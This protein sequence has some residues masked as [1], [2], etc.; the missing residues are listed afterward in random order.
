HDLQLL[1]PEILG[2][3]VA[4]S[5]LQ[6]VVRIFDWTFLFQKYRL[7]RRLLW[8]ETAGANV[9]E[10][11]RGWRL[12]RRPGFCCSGERK[13]VKVVAT[14]S[15]LVGRSVLISLVPS[16]AEADVATVDGLESTIKSAHDR[17]QWKLTPQVG[18]KYKLARKLLERG[19]EQDGMKLGILHEGRRRHLERQPG[20][21]AIERDLQWRKPASIFLKRAWRNSTKA[22]EGYL[23]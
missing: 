12:G 13:D 17:K 4:S 22:K 7:I 2:L 15:A 9:P 21:R 1:F 20:R 23:G 6:W 16:V 14:V 10:R 5:R 11:W 8:P 19:S 3:G 18:C